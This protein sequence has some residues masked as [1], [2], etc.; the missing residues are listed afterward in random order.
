MKEQTKYAQKNAFNLNTSSPPT[1]VLFIFQI[2]QN[3]LG[4]IHLTYGMEDSDIHPQ[5][6]GKR[7]FVF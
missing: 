6:T 1:T 3:K 4:A 7:G 2:D 5:M